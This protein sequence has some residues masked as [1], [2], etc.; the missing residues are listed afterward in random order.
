MFLIG[1]NFFILLNS[2]SFTFQFGALPE[3]HMFDFRQVWINFRNLL[4]NYFFNSVVSARN[5]SAIQ[6]SKRRQPAA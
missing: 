3:Y 1:D 6:C 2:Y 5:E 4:A